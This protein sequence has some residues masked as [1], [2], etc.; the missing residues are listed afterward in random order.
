MFV[1]KNR[2]GKYARR[3]G[4]NMS[5]WKLEPELFSDNIEDAYLFK[6]TR[7]AKEWWFE[8]DWV[9]VRVNIVESKEDYELWR[10]HNGKDCS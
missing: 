4:K 5:T 1:I 7:V 8:P 6:T 9:M 3:A 10:Q 2:D